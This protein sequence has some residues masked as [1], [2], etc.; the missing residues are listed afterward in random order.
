MIT[1]I[2]ESGRSNFKGKKPEPKP[3][4]SVS[5]SVDTPPWEDETQSL[6]MFPSDGAF[7]H[8]TEA[9]NIT[10]NTTELSIGRHLLYVQGQNVDNYSGVVGA[11]FL[12]VRPSVCLDDFLT[13][14]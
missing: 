4:A 5:L 13:V 11:V 3:I 12:D 10:I 2:V 6:I 8:H 9:V 7:D 1:A 14:L